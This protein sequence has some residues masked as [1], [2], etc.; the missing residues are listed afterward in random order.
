V[1]SLIWI[2]IDQ[3]KYEQ[4]IRVAQNALKEFPKSR[5]FKWGMARAYEEKNPLKAIELYKEILNSYPDIKSGNYINEITLKHII[6]QQYSRL[7]D[8]KEAIK[9]CD[10]ILSMKNIPEK[11]LDD[12]NERLERVKEL[13]K[14]LTGKN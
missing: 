3:K 13:K 12:L 11:T 10:E 9:Y 6:A 7:G 4:A 2:Y 5:T 14:E 1:N 8:K